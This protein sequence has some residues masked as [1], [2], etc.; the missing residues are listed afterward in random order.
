MPY[1]TWLETDPLNDYYHRLR[2]RVD[3]AEP[4]YAISEPCEDCGRPVDDRQ[5]SIPDEPIC[6]DLAEHL[7]AARNVRE[8]VQVCKAHRAHCPNC[9]PKVVRMA[10]QTAPEP[11][12]KAA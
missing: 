1:D 9:N 5:C 7:A 4:F 10:P 8:I 6:P 3:E 12:K 2:S 11:R